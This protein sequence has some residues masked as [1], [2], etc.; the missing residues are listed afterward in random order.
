MGF[1]LCTA[2]APTEAE[3]SQ[4]LKLLDSQRQR[5]AAGWLNPREIATGDPAKLPEVP[6]GC[7]PQDAAVWTLVS[8]VLLNLDETISKN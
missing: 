6:E 3:I 5:V 2:R 8:R 7:T 1:E 4:I